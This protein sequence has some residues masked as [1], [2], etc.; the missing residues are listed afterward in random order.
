MLGSTGCALEVPGSTGAELDVSTGAELVL[1]SD[2]T[3]IGEVE[4]V[5]VGVGV[6]GVGAGVGDA[7]AD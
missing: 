7:R 2:S 4:G 6:A 1:V 3:A 5:G